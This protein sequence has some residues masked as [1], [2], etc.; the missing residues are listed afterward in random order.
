RDATL[1]VIQRALQHTQMTQELKALRK[2]VG[3]SNDFQ[4]II[5]KSK[6][7]KD[8]FRL[9]EQ[10]SDSNSTILITG[11]SGTGKEKFAKAIHYQSI[12]KNKPFVAINCSVLPENLLESE[13]FG[14]VKGAFT[15]ATQ[16]KAGLFLEANEGT[17]FLDELGEISLS[18]QTKLLRALQE[19]EIKP[20]GS[21]KNI[22]I[23][24][25]VVV[26]TNQDLEK[27]VAE[28]TFRPDLYYRIA[29]IPIHIP[30]LRERAE[31]IPLLA[32]HFLKKYCEE[33]QKPL[34]KIST[35]AMQRL[36]SYHWPGN[37]RELEHVI[38]RAVL[39]SDGQQIT[40]DHLGDSLKLKSKEKKLPISQFEEGRSLKD[41]MEQTM[42]IVEKECILNAL[43]KTDY[44]RSQAAIILQISRGSLYNKM[45][46]YGISISPKVK[47]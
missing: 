11:E 47:Q 42:K 5:A 12:R 2:E 10:V 40:E 45:K 22:K 29:V 41:V 25:K 6:K 35:G 39:V 17:L 30:P 43:E 18:M 9:V 32:N 36:M 13:L 37:V 7:M 20:I 23:D 14:H 46:R 38:E 16:D 26:A 15:G 44:N 3:Q 27:N 4:S 8:L 24:A 1:R 19:R 28:G 34:F 21:N 31:D 33:N